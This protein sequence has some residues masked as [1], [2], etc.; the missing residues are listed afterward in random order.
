M[1]AL[2]VPAMKVLGA[3]VLGK[4]TKGKITGSTGPSVGGGGGLGASIASA[5]GSVASAAVAKK[6]SD[7]ST[8]AMVEAMTPKAQPLPDEEAIKRSTRRNAALR[9]GALGSGRA[10][11]VLS[12]DGKLGA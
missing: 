5:A 2:A 6:A 9:F 1:G 4:A 7:K 11:T 3:A 10:S 12:N 8:A